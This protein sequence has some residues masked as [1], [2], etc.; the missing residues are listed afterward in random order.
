MTSLNFTF[1]KKRDLTWTFG[2]GT[3]PSNLHGVLCARCLSCTPVAP[4]RHIAVYLSKFFLSILAAPDKLT[5]NSDPG[6][7]VSLQQARLEP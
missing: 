4:L 6:P 5:C 1:K 3:L 7:D 2:D